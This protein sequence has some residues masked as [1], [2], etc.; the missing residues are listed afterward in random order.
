[1][2]FEIHL[3]PNFWNN[4]CFSFTYCYSL[5]ISCLIYQGLTQ[6]IRLQ[7]LGR[8][9]PTSTFL[10]WWWSRPQSFSVVCWFFSDWCKESGAT[11][12]LL[13]WTELRI[14]HCQSEIFEWIFAINDSIDHGWTW[15]QASLL[16]QLL[17]INPLAPCPWWTTLICFPVMDTSASPQDSVCFINFID[18]SFRVL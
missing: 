3:Y 12:D 10:H 8:Y 16:R 4:T 17:R 5:I 14:T 11:L 2:S 18:S 6:S 9:L 7:A 1:M 15:K 13:D